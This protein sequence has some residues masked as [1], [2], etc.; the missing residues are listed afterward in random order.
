[1]PIVAEITN[2]L[3]PVRSTIRHFHL[4]EEEN[5]SLNRDGESPST[6]EARFGPILFVK[7][8]SG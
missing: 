4:E 8:T 6:G 2:D 7:S 1:M 3:L 5:I